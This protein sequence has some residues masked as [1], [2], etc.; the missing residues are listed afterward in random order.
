MFSFNTELAAAPGS[1]EESGVA[2]YL[3]VC[4]GAAAAVIAAVVIVLVVTGRKKK[5]A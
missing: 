2:W 3:W 1:P 5:V 4:I